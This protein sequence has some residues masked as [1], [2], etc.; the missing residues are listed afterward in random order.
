MCIQLD[1]KP[2]VETP[3]LDTE[4]GLSTAKYQ[5]RTKIKDSLAIVVII[6]LIPA[7]I[8]QVVRDEWKR[9]HKEKK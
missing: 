2:I 4:F 5:R 6:C 9:T 3:N 7:L 8:Y 1:M